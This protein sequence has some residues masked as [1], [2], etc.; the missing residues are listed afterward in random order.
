MSF[1]F[2]VPQELRGALDQAAADWQTN[3]KVARFWQKDSSL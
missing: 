1:R 2:A 3:N